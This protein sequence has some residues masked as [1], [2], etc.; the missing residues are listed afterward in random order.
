MAQYLIGDQRKN[1]QLIGEIKQAI[2]PL[3]VRT[4]WICS[5]SSLRN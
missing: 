5:R 3:A 4:P 2:A 1:L